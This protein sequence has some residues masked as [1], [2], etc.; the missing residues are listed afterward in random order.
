MPLSSSIRC[1]TGRL[2][3]SRVLHKGCIL[4]PQD[5]VAPSQLLVLWGQRRF[6]AKGDEQVALRKQSKAKNKKSTTDLQEEGSKDS[7]S[8]KMVL[9]ALN[10]PVTKPPPASDEEM[11]R[12]FQ[13]GR[14]YVV[15]SFEEH[16]EMEHILSCKIRLKNHTISMLPRNSENPIIRK[17]AMEVDD[18]GPPSWRHVPVWTPPIEGFDPE[19]FFDED[20]EDPWCITVVLLVSSIKRY[21]F[22]I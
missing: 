15:G 7:K 20:D 1:V 10:A 14:N 9:A 12:R 19:A 5:L 13:V 22:M 4:K 8:Y 2:Q 21:R 11:E 6:L 17:A 3:T 16:N 18:E